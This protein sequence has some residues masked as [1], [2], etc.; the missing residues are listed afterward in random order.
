MV[1]ME[2]V[3]GPG[4]RLSPR[5]IAGLALQYIRGHG[6]GAVRR[7]LG[8]A[9][10]DETDPLSL[11]RQLAPN[12]S[13]EWESALVSAWR[14]LED[15]RDAG[16]EVY[17]LDDDRY[18]ARLRVIPDPPP[19]L[20][21]RGALPEDWD[22]PLAVIGTREPDADAVVFTRKLVQAL[23]QRRDTIVVS[24]LALGIDTVA[25]QSA[26]QFGLRAVAVLANGLDTVYPKANRELADSIVANGGCL[27]SETPIGVRVSRYNLVARDRIQ[28]GLSLAT[29]LMQS[30][31]DG[32]SMHTALFTLVQERLLIALRALAN[33]PQWTGNLF[34]T[35]RDSKMWAS[36]DLVNRF[37]RF[38]DD[39]PLAIS[40]PPER[41]DDFV[42][43]GLRANFVPRQTM[44]PAT[45]RMNLG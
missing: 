32:G 42:T 43:A 45:L 11:L 10:S 9:P 34:L 27:I 23:S 6:A 14:V 41:I 39:G 26:L 28:S 29:F 7:A 37:K 33:Q 5:H 44:K 36:A 30:S 40:L 2:S 8:T 21:V 31:L 1:G 25:H 18:P 4:H 35:T 13:D 22:M 12:A 16:V 20:F 3:S 19:F 15:A 17:A 24:G 38:L